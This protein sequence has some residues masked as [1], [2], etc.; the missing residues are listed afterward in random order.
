[1]TTEPSAFVLALVTNFSSEL[2]ARIHGGI[3]ADGSV[4]KG[5]KLAIVQSTR[6]IYESFKVAIRSTAPPF[7]P[8]PNATSAPDH[9]RRKGTGVMY[10][11]DL[12]QHIR[13]SVACC[14]YSRIDPY[15]VLAH[16]IYGLQISSS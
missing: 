13:R 11:E 4:G 6:R 1:M 7:A 3:G 10:L 9:L 8:Y 15:D 12:R 16:C 14:V 2:S 5:S